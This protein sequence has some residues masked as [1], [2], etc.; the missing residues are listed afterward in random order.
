M[1]R[2]RL[3]KYSLRDEDEELCDS[4]ESFLL[5]PS[6]SIRELSEEPGGSVRG[7]DFG[8]SVSSQCILAKDSGLCSICC[9]FFLDASIDSRLIK[10]KPLPDFVVRLVPALGTALLRC[11]LEMPLVIGVSAIVLFIC[12]SKTGVAEMALD[13]MDGGGS[14]EDPS[15]TTDPSDG[16]TEYAG[17]DVMVEF[18]PCCACSRF[19]I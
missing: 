19:R 18:S 15:D 2:R 16:S 5:S 7:K 13:D 10:L 1:A 12:P 4:G 17:P 8:V 14:T 9:L 6:G 11:D 3:F